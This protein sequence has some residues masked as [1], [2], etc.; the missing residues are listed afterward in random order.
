LTRIAEDWRFI[1]WGLDPSVVDPQAYATYPD[2]VLAL[3]TSYAH[4]RGKED[5]IHWIDHTPGNAR[6]ASTLLKLFPDSLFIH[7]VRDGR[8]CAASV[9]P[10]D[11]GPNNAYMAGKWWVEQ[12]TFGLAAEALYGPRSIRIRFED[13][14]AEADWTLK[15]LCMFL[16]IPF[17]SAM[18]SG[19]DFEVVPYTSNQHELI[20]RRPDPSRVEAWRSALRPREIADFE[21]RAA[22][23]LAALGYEVSG[24]M[25]ASPGPARK[26]FLAG[27]DTYHRKV[28]NRFRHH[29]RIRN[30]T[31]V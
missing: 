23:L 29:R 2:L 31:G 20:G 21:S 5:A 10:L 7:I 27:S 4:R 13:L 28:V 15:E 30:A 24:G 19:H 8:A 22:S 6:H 25:P 26:A 12:V 16:D 11:W 1:T 18:I 14:V 17:D 3:V 9:L